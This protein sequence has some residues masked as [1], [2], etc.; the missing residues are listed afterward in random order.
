MNFDGGIVT[1]ADETSNNHLYS[2]NLLV[3]PNVTDS[4]FDYDVSASGKYQ[5]IIIII[6]LGEANSCNIDKS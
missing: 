5:I 3:D 2:V 6:V 4:T 1:F